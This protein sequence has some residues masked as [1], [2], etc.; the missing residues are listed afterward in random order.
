MKFYTS[1]NQYGNNILVR[2]INNGKA[3]QDRI[4]FKPTLFVKSQK[5]TEYKSLYG[6]SL[7]SIDFD[8]ISDAREFVN[9][10][11][12]VENFPLFGNTNYAYQYITQTFPNEIEFDISKIKIWTLDI[13]TT[14]NNGFPDITNPIE[15]I[16]LITIQDNITKQI[17]TYSR[18]EYNNYRDDVWISLNVINKQE[19]DFTEYIE[20][21]TEYND[22][23]EE[24]E[25]KCIIKQYK[26]N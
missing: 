22:I 8:S 5:Q 20:I 26:K 3:V 2:G 13:E 11:K 10:Y 18:N 12:E 7:D 14:A 1:V 25:C 17:K 24:Y 9:R 23:Y 6:E 4:Q 19:K 16:L 21:K 15:E